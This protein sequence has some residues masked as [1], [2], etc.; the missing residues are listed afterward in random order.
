MDRS[1]TYDDDGG[2]SRPADGG[3]VINIAPP[4]D[5]EIER[6]LLGNLLLY[7]AESL[8]DVL[9]AGLQPADFFREAHGEIYSAIADLYNSNEQVDMNLAAEKLRSRKTLSGVGGLA[10]LSELEAVACVGM[11]AKSYAKVIVDRATVRNL[12]K[13]AAETTEKCRS[14]PSSVEEVL[15][16]TEARVFALRDNRVTGNMVYLADALNPVYE[17][18]VKLSDLKGA[19]SGVPTGFNYLDKLTGGFQKSDMIILGARP[20]MGKTSL[21]L[22]FALNVALP[23]MR[24]GFRDMPPYAV[25]IFSLEMKL[26]QILQRLLCQ[27]GRYDLLQM[28]S[29]TLQNSEYARLTQTLSVMK[30]APIFIDDSSSQKLKPLDIRAKARRL[31]RK[32]SASGIELGLIVVDYLQLIIPNERHNNREQDV[33]EVSSSLKSLAKELDVPV[34]CCCQ[35]KRADVANPD[36]SDL[37][38]S[39]AIEQDAD[40]VAFVLRPE[41][42]F[43]DKPELEGLGQLMIKKH[44]NGPLGDV[45][46]H[47]LKYCASFTPGAFEP[48][49][50]PPSE[51]KGMAKETGKGKPRRG[52]A[53]G[54]ELPEVV[55]ARRGGGAPQE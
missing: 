47:F 6:G 17:K 51:D 1:G 30:H 9:D 41:M 27:V 14:T 36:L 40:L 7:N 43:P 13:I 24:Q 52:K 25:L 31:K 37:R 34:L 46:M 26:D 22:N 29:G 4:P 2:A 45:Y 8:P 44:R 19:L 11:M 35:L 50:P 54:A 53:K 23:E 33:A 15:D 48:Y 5:M 16:E 20:S 18:I 28:R 32:L 42:I 55:V 49:V 10:Y 21:A 39:G 38:D 3:G 12:M